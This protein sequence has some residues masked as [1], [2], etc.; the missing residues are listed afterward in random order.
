MRGFRIIPNHRVVGPHQRATRSERLE[1]DAIVDIAPKRRGRRGSPRLERFLK[2]GVPERL[3]HGPGSP[4]PRKSNRLFG[5][6]D[7]TARP[8]IIGHGR[9]KSYFAAVIPQLWRVAV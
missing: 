8:V 4:V 6:N 5:Y 1:P 9:A 3:W 2:V 7:G